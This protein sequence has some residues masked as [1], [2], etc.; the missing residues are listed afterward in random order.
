MLQWLLANHSNVCCI[1]DKC[2]VGEYWHSELQKCEGCGFG[3]SSRRGSTD[4]SDCHVCEAGTRN[5][6]YAGWCSACTPGRYSKAGATYCEKCPPGYYNNALKSVQ[7]FACPEGKFADEA[8]KMRCIACSMGTFSNKPA[9]TKCTPCPYKTYTQRTSSTA[10]LSCTGT[11]ADPLVPC[12]I[13]ILA[14][15]IV[16]NIYT[17]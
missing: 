15:T 9:A 4:E 1:L 11:D 2:D 7:C 16:N 5:K 14:I 8:G 10:C 6:D 3:R 17:I 13:G 12:K